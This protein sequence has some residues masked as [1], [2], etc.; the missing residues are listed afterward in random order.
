MILFVVEKV[1]IEMI[2]YG[3]Y[4]LRL[5]KETAYFVIIPPPLSQL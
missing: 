4:A 3:S 5:Q 2:K 1:P